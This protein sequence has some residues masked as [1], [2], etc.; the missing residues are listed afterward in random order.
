MTILKQQSIP[1]EKQYITVLL[2]LKCSFRMRLSVFLL[3]YPLSYN[4]VMVVQN[5]TLKPNDLFNL[6]IDFETLKI[7]W[8][9]YQMYDYINRP[10]SW[11][12]D[13]ID[14]S[15]NLSSADTDYSKRLV[16]LCE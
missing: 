12:F 16:P 5:Q 14:N 15:V 7:I 10:T 1:F 13:A 6:N 4:I 11:E 9:I 3:L 8:V 2:N